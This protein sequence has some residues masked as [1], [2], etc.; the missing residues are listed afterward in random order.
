[1]KDSPHRHSSKRM[2]CQ[3]LMARLLLFFEKVAPA[4]F[5]LP[6]MTIQVIRIDLCR[7][8][9]SPEGSSNEIVSSG[10]K[11]VLRRWEWTRCQTCQILS[12]HLCVIGGWPSLL[13]CSNPHP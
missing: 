6:S 5:C 9:T 4:P 3:S 13:R 8:G 7:R 2:D 10:R 12:Y 11:G 1:M